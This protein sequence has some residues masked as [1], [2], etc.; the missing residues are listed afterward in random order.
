MTLGKTLGNRDMNA[1]TIHRQD[2]MGQQGW[3]VEK[4][5]CG[6]A[7]LMHASRPHP[8]PDPHGS[9]SLDQPDAKSSQ[10]RGEQERPAAR[11][12]HSPPTLLGIFIWGAPFWKA[13]KGMESQWNGSFPARG[14]ALPGSMFKASLRNSLY[15]GGTITRELWSE[16]PLLALP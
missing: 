1:L 7:A 16:G 9:L 14:T 15:P 11:K 8:Y 4:P 6:S 10:K 12:Q 2:G 5:Q 13:K 3:K